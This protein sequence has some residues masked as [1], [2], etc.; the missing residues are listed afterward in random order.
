MQCPAQDD[1]V[2]QDKKYQK[3]KSVH[4]QPQDPKS[5][6][7]WS[8]KLAIKCKIDHQKDQNVM[9]PHKPD[10]MVKMPGQAIQKKVLKNKNCSNVDMQPQMPSYSDEQVRKPVTKYKYTY[11]KHQ[12]QVICQDK[13]SQK[14]EQTVCEGQES[15]CTQCCNRQP[16]KPGMKNKDV[17]SKEP[18]TETKLS[19]C[20]DKQCQ[21]TRCFK[22]FTRSDNI[23]SPVRPKYTDD[24]NCQFI[25]PVKP[26]SPCS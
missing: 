15:P 9:L 7:L 20:N 24:K 17:Q 4:M 21:S 8:R 10:T 16:V 26:K 11:Q 25:W 1:T 6:I 12:E 23:Q 5:Y 13:Q 14:T 3:V 2:S 18:T 22:K 19:L